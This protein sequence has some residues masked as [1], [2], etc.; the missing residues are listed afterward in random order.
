MTLEQVQQQ[1]IRAREVTLP[2]ARIARA[3]EWQ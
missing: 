1:G 2:T 3:I